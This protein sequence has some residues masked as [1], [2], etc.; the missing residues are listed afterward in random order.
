[1]TTGTDTPAAQPERPSEPTG[2]E[3]ADAFERRVAP[4]LKPPFK[5]KYG[6][7]LMDE[8]DAPGPE[9]SYI[10]EDWFSEADRSVIAGPSKAG[11]SFLA[12]HL[13]LCIV[14]DMPFFGYDIYLPGLVIYQAG[15]GARGV[16]KR[17]RAWR[18]HFKVEYSRKT[19]FALVQSPI[20]LYSKDGDTKGFIDECIGIVGMF[21]GVPLRMIVIDT[22]AT[23]T[24]GADENSG[25]DMSI[26]LRNVAQISAATKSHVCLVHHM[27]ANGDKVRGHTSIYANSDQVAL[28]RRNE[29]TGVRTVK[30]DKQ[31]D[32]E[33]GKTFQ[34][35]LLQI[36]LG[37]YPNGKEITS[38]VCVPVGEKEA[39]RKAEEAKGFAL[40]TDETLFMQAFF[41]AE[42]KHGQPV[43]VEMQLPDKVRSVVP[44]AEVRRI[45]AEA[46]PADDLV[47]RAGESDSDFSTRRRN[48]LTKR[49][50]AL[51]RKL[52][53]LGVIGSRTK[54]ESDDESSLMWFMGKPLRAFP[55][56]IPRKEVI[57]PVP[58]LGPGFGTDDLDDVGF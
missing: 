16:K 21:D 20:D 40:S 57:Q 22:L 4:L 2:I 50:S 15:E 34:F 11:K 5:P 25:K 39:I 12:T 23:A 31:K 7:L 41:A 32:G 17:L 58:A 10:V 53:Q 55:H 43:P 35:S 13:G 48:A 24:G 46:N 45:Y 42:K 3:D 33:D 14:H 28:V 52:T 49:I 8:L 56:T 27:N 38:C 54:T 1:M 44:Y 36:V 30:L 6:T 37:Q 29:T 47:Q 26:V 51:R 18:K 19:P 9:F